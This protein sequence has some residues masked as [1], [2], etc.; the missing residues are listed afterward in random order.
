MT[1]LFSAPDSSKSESPP[2]LA[3]VRVPKA[4]EVEWIL[5]LNEDENE[6]VRS[7]FYYEQVIAIKCNGHL[8][9]FIM[10]VCMIRNTEVGEHT[11]AFAFLLCNNMGTKKS[12]PIKAED[13]EAFWEIHKGRLRKALWQSWHVK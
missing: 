10:C 11:L 6:L 2:Y 9:F 13:L 7:E 3:V 5:S 8:S 12:K 4:V 1:H